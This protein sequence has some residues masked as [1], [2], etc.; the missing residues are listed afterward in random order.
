[1]NALPLNPEA[2]GSSVAFSYSSGKGFQFLLYNL[3]NIFI[4]QKSQL[5]FIKI[6]S[7]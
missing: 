2:Q 4:I 5:I 6:P 3:D 1:M 7:E